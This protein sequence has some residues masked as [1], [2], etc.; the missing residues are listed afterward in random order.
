[1]TS[2]IR[3]VGAAVPE[4]YE[5]LCSVYLIPRKIQDDI[6]LQNAFEI[7]DVLTSLEE[8]TGDQDEF[9]D[10]L[11]R[12]VANYEEKTIPAPTQTTPLSRLKFLLEMNE[13]NASALSTL[14]GDP[15]RSIGTRLLSGERELS[16]TQIVILA[17]RFK[18]STD[19]FLR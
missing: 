9:L 18:V 16:K 5:D 12:H 8:L 14:L 2:S 19:L 11:T 4:S 13:M 7:L 3:H 1:M 6:G 10:E 15:G 17:E